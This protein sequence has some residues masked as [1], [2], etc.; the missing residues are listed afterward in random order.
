MQTHH[1]TS[2]IVASG[3]HIT[4]LLPL[5]RWTMFFHDSFW[6]LR[7]RMLA[8]WSEKW[9]QG[10]IGKAKLCKSANK[11]GTKKELQFS[12]LTDLYVNQSDFVFIHSALSKEEISQLQQS[13][14]SRGANRS[15]EWHQKIEKGVA[16]AKIKHVLKKRSGIC[17]SC[18]SKIYHLKWLQR[19][20][21]ATDT[22]SCAKLT[23]F[24]GSRLALSQ[25]AS[26]T[27]CLHIKTTWIQAR[28]LANSSHSWHQP[29]T[30]CRGMGNPAVPWK[31]FNIQGDRSN[32]S[33]RSRIKSS[34]Q[35]TKWKEYNKRK[36]CGMIEIHYRPRGVWA[37]TPKS[38]ADLECTKKMYIYCRNV[39]EQTTKFNKATKH[40][41][42][43]FIDVRTCSGNRA[44]QRS[45]GLVP[46]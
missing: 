26:F 18:R 41:P 28:Q 17:L 39:G 13:N 38:K 25:Y 10:D 29:K 21:F 33:W 1:W 37:V 40:S 12:A 4:P 34:L 5:T 27:L 16:D 31:L 14:T 15:N 11:F 2:F 42:T 20:L 7:A 3:S 30:Q 36:E 6:H 35:S 9:R 19:H 22:W 32:T 44:T 23:M 43:S 8:P 24:Y 46:H 45:G